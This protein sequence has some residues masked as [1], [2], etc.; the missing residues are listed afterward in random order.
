[1][2][3][4]VTWGLWVEFS[5]STAPRPVSQALLETVAGLG[6]GEAAAHP[7]SL[8]QTAW[9]TVCQSSSALCRGSSLPHPMPLHNHHS[10]FTN[11]LLSGWGLG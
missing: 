8:A 3:T 1:V 10:L 6:R 4:Y 9:M 11:N 7:E 2:P 5:L